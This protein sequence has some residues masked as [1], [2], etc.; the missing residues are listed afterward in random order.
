MKYPGQADHFDGR[1]SLPMT[2]IRGSFAIFAALLVAAAAFMFSSAVSAESVAED[3][4]VF[5]ASETGIRI[6]VNARAT[7]QSAVVV[8]ASDASEVAIET[9]IAAAQD[10]LAQVSDA[11]AASPSTLSAF[12]FV[13]LGFTALDYS[14]S[15]DYLS[16]QAVIDGPMSD[17]YSLLLANMIGLRDDAASAVDGT[18]VAAQSAVRW[19]SAALGFGIPALFAFGVSLRSKRV[20]RA[21]EITE[22]LATERQLRKSQEDFIANVS[23]ELRTPLTSVHGFLQLLEGGFVEDEHE[24][25]EL[26]HLMYGESAELVRMV[27]DLLV[28][29]RLG[30]GALTYKTESTRIR[31]EIEEVVRVASSDRFVLVDVPDVVVRVDRLRLRQVM[32][33]LLSNA[34]RYGGAE[35]SIKGKVLGDRLEITV[36]DDGPGVSADMAELL[37]DRFVTTEE[38]ALAKGGFGLGLSIA[39]EI[40]N[41]MGGSIFYDR[42]DGETRFIFTVLLSTEPVS[43]LEEESHRLRDYQLVGS[44]LTKVGSHQPDKNQVVAAQGPTG[45]GAAIVDRRRGPRRTP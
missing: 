37:F 29:A 9:S 27:D 31:R 32:R 13:E 21:R 19:L 36:G 1:Y 16:S 20:T 38:P 6:L 15:G 10:S 23:H 14:R 40:V 35:V 7:V 43:D 34:E 12:E 4:A 42:R 45:S 41:G 39:K 8:G 28:A 30:N 18:R 2:I 25:S 44:T 33:N 24:R 5:Q 17:E 22:A 3:A 11:V 26:V